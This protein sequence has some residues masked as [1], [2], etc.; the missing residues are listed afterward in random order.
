MAGEEHRGKR[1]ADLLEKEVPVSQ[2]LRRMRK[3]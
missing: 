2:G 1:A 3:D